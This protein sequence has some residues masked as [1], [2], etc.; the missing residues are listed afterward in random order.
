MS[1]RLNVL[2]EKNCADVKI[3]AS[4]SFKPSF[5]VNPLSKKKRS[6]ES[7]WMQ[8]AFKIFVFL[9]PKLL[10][11]NYATFEKVYNMSAKTLKGW[12]YKEEARERWTP[13]L[14]LMTYGDVVQKEQPP[15]KPR[16][17]IPLDSK[18]NIGDFLLTKKGTPMKQTFFV[19]GS[20][21]LSG[22][23]ISLSLEARLIK[24]N[25][26]RAF[27]KK[28]N[29]VVK[30]KE[31][32]DY[33]I[34]MV[35][36]ALE[37]GNPVT[38][39]AIFL[40][41]KDKHKSGEFCDKVLG[42]KNPSVFKMW[43]LRVFKSNGFSNR[44]TTV[45][46]VLLDDFVEQA[47]QLRKEFLQ[48]YEENEVDRLV[49]AD[50][51]FMQFYYPSDSVI[52]KKGATRVDTGVKMHNEKQGATIMVSAELFQGRL[53]EPFVVLDGAWG[54][55]LMRSEKFSKR[56]GSTVVFNVN[57]WM[58]GQAFI[59]YLESL[60]R[61]FLGNRIGLIVDHFSGHYSQ[62]VKSYIEDT[63]GRDNTYIMIKMIP[64]GLTSVLQVGDVGINH[65]LKVLVKQDFQERIAAKR[66]G[67]VENKLRIDRLQFLDIVEGAFKTLMKEK[68]DEWI[69]DLFKKCGQD[70]EEHDGGRFEKHLKECESRG[71]K[72]LERPRSA[73]ALD[74]NIHF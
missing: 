44:S 30:W 25:T 57:H 22:K 38:K 10:G 35:T 21:G 47:K 6:T 14:K 60:R 46:A 51:T 12:L 9:H 49:A 24:K 71:M 45:S 28:G 32:R 41:L 33:V 43:L 53:L 8:R 26:K 55:N 1:S 72:V 5:A 29:V 42:N 66:F 59:V 37:T 36:K 68:S 11:K 17:V 54:G 4:K 50:E 16:V 70:P 40:D 64:K 73:L 34:E 61:M 39:E 18:V 58:S 13:I 48:W 52:A 63:N 62:E 19:H 65:D 56:I 31:E 67:I 69:R 74:G 27:K 23:K 7:N 20:L 15:F 3:A 2:V